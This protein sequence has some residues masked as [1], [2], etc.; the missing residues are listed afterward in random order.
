MVKALAK[1]KDDAGKKGGGGGGQGG[2]GQQGSGRVRS[3]AEIKLLS[4]T[5]QDLNA[6]VADNREAIEDRVASGQDVAELRQQR[7]ELAQ[8]QGQIADLTLDLLNPGDSAPENNPDDLPDIRDDNPDSDLLPPLFCL[9]QEIVDQD[10][11]PKVNSDTEPEATA[12]PSNDDVPAAQNDD[13]PIDGLLPD[14]DV[15]EDIQ[16]GPDGEP[17]ADDQLGGDVDPITRIAEKMRKVEELLRAQQQET[18]PGAAPLQEQIVLELNELLKQM[19]K[20]AQQQASSGNSGR[21]PQQGQRSKVKLPSRPRAG[22]PGQNKSSKQSR[23][24]SERIGKALAKVDVDELNEFIK[25]I[26]GHLP[27]KD[28]E[29]LRQMAAEEIMPGHDVAIEKYFRRLA[30]EAND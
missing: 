27:E 7:I 23:D 20:Q 14:L 25:N 10:P 4:L 30:E 5:Q 16:L 17:L 26:W 18:D 15:G 22:K 29:R 12:N 8:E 19:K 11:A 1:D 28:R 6:R 24:S 3:L 13:D 2:G 21:S 9:G